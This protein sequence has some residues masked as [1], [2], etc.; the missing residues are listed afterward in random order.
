MSGG[1]SWREEL[2][3][4]GQLSPAI[5]EE[6][7]TQHGDRGRKAIDAVGEHR[8]KRYNDFTIVVGW[9]DEYIVEDDHCDCPDTQYN[10]E[11]EDPNQ[12]CWHVLASIIA[13]ALGEVD[14]YD[15]WYGEIADLL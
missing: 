6:I 11:A 3:A 10:L 8:V 2:S 5:V 4:S 9:H 1:Q 12:L 15:D 14:E 7:L 13:E